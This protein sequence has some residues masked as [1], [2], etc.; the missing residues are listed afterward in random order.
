MSHAVTTALPQV[1]SYSR[2]E[3]V[4]PWHNPTPFISDTCKG[5]DS[6]T[7]SSKTLHLF[8]IKAWDAA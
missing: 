5:G 6:L 4:R 8:G 3:T 2:R 1:L 7:V